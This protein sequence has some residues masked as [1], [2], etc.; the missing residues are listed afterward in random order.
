MTEFLVTKYG[1]HNDQL[2]KKF[3]GMDRYRLRSL[4]KIANC[5]HLSNDQKDFVRK[6]IIYKLNILISGAKK[7]KNFK[8]QKEYQPLLEKWQLSGNLVGRKRLS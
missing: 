7:R 1:G 2:S 6:E 3:W 5:T 4:L 8:L